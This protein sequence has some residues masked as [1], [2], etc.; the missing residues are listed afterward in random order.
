[1]VGRLSSDV[2]RPAWIVAAQFEISLVKLRVLK[3]VSSMQ[4]IDRTD[5]RKRVHWKKW[6]VLLGVFFCLL[7]GMEL[8]HAWHRLLVAEQKCMPDYGSLKTQH[9]VREYSFAPTTSGWSVTYE[10]NPPD[11]RGDG[12]PSITVDFWGRIVWA[13]PP[14]VIDAVYQFQGG[15]GALED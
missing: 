7:Y 3:H 5:S 2:K 6:V 13:T 15:R 10:I 11:W 1:M 14:Y 9:V 4:E 8:T 12:N